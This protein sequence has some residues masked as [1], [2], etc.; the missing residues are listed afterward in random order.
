MQ[1]SDNGLFRLKKQN[2]V[3]RVIGV[4]YGLSTSLIVAVTLEASNQS[5]EPTIEKLRGKRMKDHG[6][7]QLVVGRG[8]LTVFPLSSASGSYKGRRKQL[9]E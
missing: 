7:G 4:G 8:S 5:L 6:K 9:L 3:W 2:G 1:F